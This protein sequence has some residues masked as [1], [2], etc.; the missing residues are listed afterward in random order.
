MHFP[1]LRSLILCSALVF[2]P[3]LA[4]AQVPMQAWSQMQQQLARNQ[5]FIARQIDSAFELTGDASPQV[6]QYS[7]RVHH[8]DKNGKPVRELIASSKEAAQAYKMDAMSLSL[9]VLAA[10]RP[11]EFLLSPSSIVFVR[12]E[13]FDGV[14]ASVYEVKT[15]VGKG[16]YPTVAMI[17][18][19]QK[20]ATPI[21]IEGVIDKLPLPG[22]K[23]AQFVLRYATASNGLTLPGAIQ[24]NYAVS[25]FFQSGKVSFLQT[26]SDWGNG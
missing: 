17:W 21:K 3:S 6:G 8:V 22:I 23:K 2:A 14:A 7:T 11:E 9:G 18:V 12:D 16:I 10:N 5:G 25:I 26:F 19:R 20:D 13:A 24:I 1:V 4:K 15:S